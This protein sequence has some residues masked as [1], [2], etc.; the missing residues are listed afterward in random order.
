VMVARDYERGLQATERARELNPNVAFVSTLVGAAQLF[1]GDPEEALV[2]IGDAMRVS[3]SDPSAFLFYSCAALGHLFC[4]RAVEACEL[5]KKSARMYD[6]WDTT[7]WALIPALVQLDRV[8]EARSALSKLLELSPTATV[9]RLR[10]L[11]PIRNPESLK[12]I[13]DGMTIAGLS[14]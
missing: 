8:E 7:Y 11:L 6:D 1:G 13:L 12:M 3:P 4:G 10:E 5:A 9:S 2:C 14:D